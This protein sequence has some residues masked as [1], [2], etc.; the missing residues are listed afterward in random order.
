M[1]RSKAA[2]KHPPPSPRRPRAA[3]DRSSPPSLE[4]LLEQADALPADTRSERGGSGISAEVKARIVEIQRARPLLSAKAIAKL[5]GV[6][7]GSVHNVTR[8]ARAR[9]V[10]Q[11]APA[12]GPAGAS[13]GAEE[14]PAED[15]PGTPFERLERHARWL[16][17]GAE[18]LRKSG[19]VKGGAAVQD[20][21]IKVLEQLRELRPPPEPNHAADPTNVAARAEVLKRVEALVAREEGGRAALAELERS[22]GG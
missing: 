16:L 21:T 9:A 1:P 12:D 2:P 7:A 5:V 20:R 13:G 4:E 6:S 10:A 15:E 3:L 17:R 22:L 8:S 11:V 14:A 18:A 19:D